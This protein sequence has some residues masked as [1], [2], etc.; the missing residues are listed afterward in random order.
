MLAAAPD[1]RGNLFHVVGD[2]R[3]END[4][5]PAGNARTQRQPA[6]AMPHDFRHDDAVMAVGGAVQ[7]VNGFG[8]NVHRGGV[9]KG[10][11]RHGHVVVNC[12]GQGDDIEAGLVQPQRV[13]LRAAAAEADQRSPGPIC[14]SFPRWSR[15]CRACGRQ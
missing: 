1:G 13:L 15:S 5:R 14:R 4:I 12:L 3:N 6:R 8:G 2:F 11:V 7:A 10:G 9:T